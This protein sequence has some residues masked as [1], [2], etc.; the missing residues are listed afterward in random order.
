MKKRNLNLLFTVSLTAMSAIQAG[1]LVPFSS[2]APFSGIVPFSGSAI[3]KIAEGASKS[4]NAAYAFVGAG[5]AGA[6]TA[7]ESVSDKSEPASIVVETVTQAV[8]AV[9]QPLGY[10]AQAK[11]LWNNFDWN[12]F[13]HKRAVYGATGLVA[14]ATVMK[15]YDSYKANQTVSAIENTASATT[16]SKEELKAETPVVKSFVDK[17]IQTTS[18]VKSVSNQ[19]SQ[20]AAPVVA[21]AEAVAPKAAPKIETPAVKV[22][23]VKLTIEQIAQKNALNPHD[24]IGA[25]KAHG[26]TKVQVSESAASLRNA[27]KLND[28]QVRFVIANIR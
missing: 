18:E 22:A 3:S 27:G 6:M 17:E 15:L 13:E 24:I 20:A 28:G 4:Y 12:K 9:V 10:M 21:K 16:E 7:A 1:P 25:L 2:L 23:E 8:P 5:V 26:Y 11:S 19:E 14:F